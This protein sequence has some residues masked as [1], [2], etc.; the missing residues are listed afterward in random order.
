MVRK[1]IACIFGFA[2]AFAL[3][4]PAQAVTHNVYDGTISSTYLTI[5]KDIANT[6]DFDQYVAFRSGSNEYTLAVGYFQYSE[7]ERLLYL[8]KEMVSD[9]Q[10]FTISYSNGYNDENFSYTNEWLEDFEVYVG[11]ELIY[12]NVNNS[13]FFPTLKDRGTDYEKTIAFILCVFLVML[14][15]NRIFFYRKR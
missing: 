4:V 15:V 12:T 7:S 11:D 8:D 5:L 1:V 2:L 9:C 14:I 13:E 3:C 10:V 6:I